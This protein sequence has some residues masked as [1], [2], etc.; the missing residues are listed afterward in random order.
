MGEVKVQLLSGPHA[1]TYMYEAD[2][3]ETA[4]ELLEHFIR[5]RWSWRLCHTDDEDPAVMQEW[6]QGDL[7]ARVM[8]ALLDGRGIR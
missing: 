6:L 7:L 1:G 8:R 3:G 5:N 4:L 2:N